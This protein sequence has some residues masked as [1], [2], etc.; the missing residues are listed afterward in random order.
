MR[1]EVSQE[2]IKKANVPHELFLTNLIGNHILM[3]VAAGGVAGSFPWV[4]AMIPVISFGILGYTLWRARKAIARDPWYPMCHWQVCAR[5]SKIFIVMLSMLMVIMALGWVGYTYLGMMREAVLALIG[6][7]GIL[8]VMVTVLILIIIE[9]EALYHANQAKLPAW[10]V[11][12][13]PNPDAKVIEE[14]KP[15]YYD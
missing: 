13:F 15:A 6:G 12:R 1:F 8:P 10:V 11:E 14:V 5:R 4:M 3:A 2:E 9:S 7:V